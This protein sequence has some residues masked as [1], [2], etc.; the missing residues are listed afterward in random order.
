MSR[1]FGPFGEV[2]L[3][4]ID[5]GIAYFGDQYLIDAGKGDGSKEMKIPYSFDDYQECIA[6][7]IH[8]KHEITGFVTSE[9]GGTYYATKWV[10]QKK[11]ALAGFF[12]EIYKPFSV[13]AIGFKITKE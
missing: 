3:S 10:T 4:N 5:S 8:R 2:T 7:A 11:P 6:T 12:I 13:P 1:F 9:F